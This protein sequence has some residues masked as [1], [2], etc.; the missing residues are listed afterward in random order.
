MQGLCWGGADRGKG[1]AWHAL[2]VAAVAR[3]VQVECLLFVTDCW[4]RTARLYPSSCRSPKLPLLAQVTARHRVAAS[5]ATGAL[6]HSTQLSLPLLGGAAVAKAELAEPPLGS[7]AAAAQ[8]AVVRLELQGRSARSRGLAGGIKLQPGL[9]DKFRAAD[10]A[11]V[12]SSS[13]NGSSSSSSGGSDSDDEM[14]GSSSLVGDA[15]KQAQRQCGRGRVPGL[16]LELVPGMV[17]DWQD[18]SGRWQQAWGGQLSS[19]M[20]YQARQRRWTLSLSHKLTGWLS[21]V[22]SLVC[23]APGEA[24]AGAVAAEESN[25]QIE[26]AASS[27]SV[28]SCLGP[29]APQQQ[30]HRLSSHI[31]SYAAA[32]QLRKAALKLTC[33]LRQPARQ[34]R[35][36]TSY[37]AGEGGFTHGVTYRRGRSAADWQQQTAWYDLGLQARPHARQLLLKFDFFAPL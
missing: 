18:V 8:H 33:R 37:D 25:G 29:D 34:L 20:A 13:A 11:A 21:A 14:L 36:E 7:E 19:S 4:Q 15:E 32:A 12:A 16:K 30:L 1:C 17:R 9:A 31:R 23:D 6:R 10:E 5:Q 24:A 35:L 22:G 2:A 3:A 27:S 26:A 28:G